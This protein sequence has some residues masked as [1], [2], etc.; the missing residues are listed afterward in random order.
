MANKFKI[1]DKVKVIE[2]KSNDEEHGVKIGME[3]TV[4][5]DD[6]FPMCK[7]DG[8]R[9]ERPM[10]ESQLTRC[11]SKKKIKTPSSTDRKSMPVF[12]GVIKYFPLAMM[13][14]SKVSKNGNDKHSPGKP[15]FWDRT[16]SGDEADS[17][18]RHLIDYA[19]DEGGVDEEGIR[20]SA[21]IAWRCLALL[22]KELEDGK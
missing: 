19:M 2:L 12:S 3:G 5:E 1:G 15:L 9:D 6:G 4:M 17:L 11:L 7:L 14:L 16:K 10:Y 20:H 22:Q 21:R 18:T 13:E 8:I